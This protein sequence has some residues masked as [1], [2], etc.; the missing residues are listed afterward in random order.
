MYEDWV[1]QHYYA[2]KC[3]FLATGTPIVSDLA[4][5]EQFMS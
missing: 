2:E 4:I 5:N 3:A 1:R